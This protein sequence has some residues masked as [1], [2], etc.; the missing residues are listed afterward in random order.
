M[1]T[2][3]TTFIFNIIPNI[4]CLSIEQDKEW[5]KDLSRALKSFNI[6]SEIYL[7]KFLPFRN[8]GKF[9]KLPN[10]KPD[11]IYIDGPYFPLKKKNFNTFTG[12]PAYYDFET[13]F[14]KNHFP[15]VIMIEGRTD[16]VDAILNSP[17]AY[18]YKFYGEFIFYI[19]RK[20]FFASLSLR[21][22][23]VFVLKS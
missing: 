5:L 6:N 21:R 3:R 9:K 20:F 23:G 10:F 13:F 22:H 18:K 4:K 7:S 15:K 8:G 11:M 17:F 2:G 1:G 12:K 14:L 16:T 19:Q